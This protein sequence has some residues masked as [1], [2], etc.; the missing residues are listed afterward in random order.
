[1]VAPLEHDFMEHTYVPDSIVPPIPA[2]QAIMEEVYVPHRIPKR[3]LFKKTV[4]RKVAKRAE[5]T[6]A[7]N[8]PNPESSIDDVEE[9]WEAVPRVEV[10]AGGTSKNQGATMALMVAHFVAFPVMEELAW[11]Y[12]AIERSIGKEPHTKHLELPYEF[13]LITFHTNEKT[14]ILGV[15]VNIGPLPD[16]DYS[17]FM[18]AEPDDISWPVFK[19]LTMG[20]GMIPLLVLG[21]VAPQARQRLNL[22]S[23][24]SYFSRPFKLGV[25]VKPNEK[26]RVVLKF[27]WMQN[28]IGIALDQMIPGH[29]TIPLS[30]YYFWP[31]KD[32]WEELKVLLESKPWISQIER[33]HLLNQ[34]TD[35]I[36][37]WQTAGGNLL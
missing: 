36:N 3:R 30:P 8:V 18:T 29:G 15:K 22:W 31:R 25:V 13:S 2:D 34:A 11:A 19:D 5:G 12:M 6:F 17:S 10:Q 23:L 35:I 32:A 4:A 16:K 26:P 7:S 20:Y 33:I 24:D 28:D 9:K 14:D 1:M 21:L 37:L 27:I